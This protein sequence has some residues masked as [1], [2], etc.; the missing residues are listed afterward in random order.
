MTEITDNLTT[1]V[2]TAMD[3]I[4][5]GLVKELHAQ[6]HHLTG[7]L[8][9][10]I[11]YEVRREAGRVTAIM[12]ANDYGIFMEFGVPASRIP[13]G[14]KRRGGGGGKSKYIQGLVR[15]FEL[16]G[17]HGREAL[18]AAFATARK[19]KREGMPTRGSYAFSSNN[20]RTGFVRNTLEQ[21]LPK[22][23]EIVGR[24]AGAVVDLV[25]AETIKLEPYRIAV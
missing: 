2:K 1:A 22:I 6:G 19:Q 16:R 8:E 4:R 13:Y 17:V 11:Q 5:R 12:T 7:A 15:F 18:S 14:G 3:E 25:I 21:Y 20:R 24:E 10:S 9:R 23:T